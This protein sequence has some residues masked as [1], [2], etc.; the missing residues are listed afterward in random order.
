MCHVLYIVGCPFSFGHRVVCSSLVTRRVWSQ[1]RGNQIPN[2]EEEQTTQWPK[3]KIQK[4]K[5]R[6]T[7]H[8]H[9][10]KDRV[11]RT[12]L[13]SRGK[14]RCSVRA[15]SSRSTSGTRH[16]NLVTI[17]ET[18]FTFCYIVDI[19]SLNTS[20]FDDYVDHIDPMWVWNKGYLK[21]S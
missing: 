7:K 6:S 1:Q 2:M 4:D 17:S 8:T 10:T 14:L 21:Y 19:L 15:G 18:N 5:Q 12:P 16:V 13:K 11:K 20:R 9:N 3:E